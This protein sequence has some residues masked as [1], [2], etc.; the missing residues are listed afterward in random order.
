[1]SFKEHLMQIY[2][3]ETL[4]Q[5]YFDTKISELE[6]RQIRITK[7]VEKLPLA[8]RME[9]A[10]ARLKKQCR[11]FSFSEIGNNLS[12]WSDDSIS[13]YKRLNLTHTIDILNNRF[14]GVNFQV[15]NSVI[16]AWWGKDIHDM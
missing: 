4:S 2:H 8:Q 11:L 6:R 1:M 12:Y 15:S 3:D 14:P 5:K 16:I 9:V 13:K 10:A 7:K